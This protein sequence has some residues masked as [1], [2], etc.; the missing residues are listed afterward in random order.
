MEKNACANLVTV[1]GKRENVLFVRLARR[2]GRKD[3]QAK[4]GIHFLPQLLFSHLAPN[5]DNL[6]DEMKQ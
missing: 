3:F 2:T 6:C 4:I 5:G 1:C